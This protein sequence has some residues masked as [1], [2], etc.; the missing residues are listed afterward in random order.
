MVIK[1][2][3]I[4]PSETLKIFQKI[5]IFGLKTNHLATLEVSADTDYVGRTLLMDLST[6]VLSLPSFHIF[7]IFFFFQYY[8]PVLGSR[9]LPAV[10]QTSGSMVRA[11]SIV[12]NIF[13]DVFGK[14]L[15]RGC[16]LCFV[17]IVAK[18]FGQCFWQKF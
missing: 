1:Y 15:R 10:S 3:N 13:S 11:L 12:E 7:H 4:F 16:R 18:V 6:L 5:W 9:C 14:C 8:L 2:I 17:K